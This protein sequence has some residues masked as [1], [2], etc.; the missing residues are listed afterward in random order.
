M[1]RFTFPMRWHA[2]TQVQAGMVL[3]VRISVK[4]SLARC[5]FAN[6]A[7]TSS[8]CVGPATGGQGSR[9]RR[10]DYKACELPHVAAFLRHAPARKRLRHPHRPG[11]ARS[12][13]CV[14]D[15]DLHART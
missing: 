13:G 5:G 2:S 11:T 9:A 7:K 15:D 8:R 12:L 6:R 3:A 4:E 10:G 1:A 14:Y